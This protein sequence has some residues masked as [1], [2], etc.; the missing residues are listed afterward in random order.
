MDSDVFPNTDA[1]PNTIDRL[2]GRLGRT[3]TFAREALSVVIRR[4]G[5][6]LVVKK[7]EFSPRGFYPYT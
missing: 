3:F 1:A 4:I 2:P 6:I 5:R 7:P